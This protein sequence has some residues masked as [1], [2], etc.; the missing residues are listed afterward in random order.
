[1]NNTEFSDL[2]NELLA[3]GLRVEGI[4]LACGV[5]VNAVY[6]WKAGSK[7]PRRQHQAKLRELLAGSEQNG[8]QPAHDT[9][10]SG[11]G[12]EKGVGDGI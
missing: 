7:T 8:N 11:S 9:A 1:M 12:S 6:K 5:G 2:I 10:G 4:A 3:L